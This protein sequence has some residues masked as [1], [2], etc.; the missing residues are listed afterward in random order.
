[1]KK[2]TKRKTPI[3]DPMPLIT[4]RLGR[5]RLEDKVVTGEHKRAFESLGVDKRGLLP[6][7]AV[8]SIEGRARSGRLCYSQKK[9]LNANV[10]S[11]PS[12]K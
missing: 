2:K 10:S 9:P 11:K 5:R 4:T 12:L 6:K 8:R 3:I 7:R 1:M